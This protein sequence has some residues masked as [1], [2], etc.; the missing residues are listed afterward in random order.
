MEQLFI[1]GKTARVE[2][3]AQPGQF[4][5][6]RGSDR[7][8][9][10][11]LLRADCRLNGP[12]LAVIASTGKKTLRVASVPSVAVISTG[13]ELIDLGRPVKSFQI[14]PSNAHGI[15][16][17]LQ[18]RGFTKIGV[19]KVRD[20]RKKIRALF[21]KVLRNFDVLI[22]TGGVSMGKFDFVP[23]VLKDLGV[24]PRFHKVLQK[25]GKP[26][27]FGLSKKRQ[28]VFA[29][30]GNPVSTMVCLHRYVLPRPE[31]QATLLRSC[32]PHARLTLFLPVREEW[33]GSQLG[34]VPELYGGS[35]D[36]AALGESDGFI[37]LPAG[38]RPVKAG[39]LVPYRAW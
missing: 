22:V 34:V 10:A 11:L 29:L 23:G 15:R 27:W 36:L 32:A 8:K 1:A 26:F 17:S 13:D 30:P 38:D 12:Q 20:D 21:T 39:T 37:E 16:A 14:R 6:R 24:R 28:P 2:G 5:H 18:A 35:G 19:F 25:P 3:E 7:K 33:K 4:I 9:G 31:I